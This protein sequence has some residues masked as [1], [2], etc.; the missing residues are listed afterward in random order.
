MCPLT[1][2][3]VSARG[4]ER[5]V[6]TVSEI[7][8]GNAERA[9]RVS[10]LNIF[11]TNSMGVSTDYLVESRSPRAVPGLRDERRANH[12]NFTVPWLN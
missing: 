3:Y 8:K 7:L 12:L 9:N 10:P 2:L 11:S 5:L 1:V 4:S 6:E